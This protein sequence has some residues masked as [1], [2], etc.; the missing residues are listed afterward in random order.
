MKKWSYVNQERH[1]HSSST[2]NKWKQSKTTLNKYVGGFWCERQQEMDFFTG[3]SVIMDYGLGFGQKCLKRLNGR[4]L[5]YKH[6]AFCYT[7][8]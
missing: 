5:S 4:F 3:G 6:A 1:M 8:Y 2:G 7:R